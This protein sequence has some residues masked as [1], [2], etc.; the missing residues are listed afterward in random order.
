MFPYVIYKNEYNDTP[1]PSS[2]P[3]GR[4]SRT[5]KCFPDGA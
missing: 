4:V 5:K 3:I 1:F 2:V